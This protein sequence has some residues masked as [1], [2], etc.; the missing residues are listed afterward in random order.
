MG[1]R[2][3][4]RPAGVSVRNDVAYAAGFHGGRGVQILGRV[5]S[6][7]AYVAEHAGKEIPHAQAAA[8]A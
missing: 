6:G 5:K 3:A 4:R 8:R 7:E 1:N 2:R